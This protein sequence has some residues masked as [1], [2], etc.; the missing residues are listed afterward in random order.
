MRIKLKEKTGQLNDLH[1]AWPHRASLD[2]PHQGFGWKLSTRAGFSQ[3]WG[4]LGGLGALTGSDGVADDV[5][6]DTDYAEVGH[7]GDSVL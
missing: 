6:N 2:E 5:G 1:R 7:P 3:L 4:S